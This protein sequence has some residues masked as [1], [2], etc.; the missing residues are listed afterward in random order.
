MNGTIW[1]FV[2]ALVLMSIMLGFLLHLKTGEINRPGPSKIGGYERSDLFSPAEASFFRVLELAAESRWRVFAKVR[3]A[4]LIRHEK[5]HGRSGR[6]T[7][8][9]RI[10]SK[11]VDFVL[12][13]PETLRVAGV[14]ELDDKSHGTLERGIRDMNVD[15]ALADAGIPVLRVPAKRGYMPVDLKQQLESA[16]QGKALKSG[17]DTIANAVWQPA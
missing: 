15:Q 12:C 6:Q 13:D 16:F 4:D 1:I 3:L 5:G 14:V 9:N 2:A 10:T 7:A 11:H 17:T 8:L